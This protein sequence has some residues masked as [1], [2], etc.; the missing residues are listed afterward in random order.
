MKS[1]IIR[2]LLIIFSILE[3]KCPYKFS[4]LLNASLFVPF[5]HTCSDYPRFNNVLGSLLIPESIEIEPRGQTSWYLHKIPSYAQG[6]EGLSA[7]S[8]I[9]RSRN[10]SAH[11]L[12]WHGLRMHP[13][14]KPLPIGRQAWFS[15]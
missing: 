5:C 4:I 7:F 14:A 9:R 8:E 13:Q 6:F 10:T 11:K 3:K 1:L 15:A 12:F 2:L